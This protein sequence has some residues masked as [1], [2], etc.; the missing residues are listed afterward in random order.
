MNQSILYNLLD[1]QG[2]EIDKDE[3]FGTVAKM[4]RKIEALKSCTGLAGVADAMRSA[5]EAHVG[6]MMFPGSAGA[7]GAARSFQFMP[8]RSAKLPPLERAGAGPSG[9]A[10]ALAR[11]EPGWGAGTIPTPTAAAIGSSQSAT[12]LTPQAA[13][14]LGQGA[15]MDTI[16]SRP[17]TAQF[18]NS[19]LAERESFA[20]GVERAGSAGSTVLSGGLVGVS[21]VSAPSVSALTAVT[22]SAGEGGLSPAPAGA[23]AAAG[24]AGAVTASMSMAS[25]GSVR[26]PG[27]SQSR[28]KTRNTWVPVR[29]LDAL[30]R[31]FHVE[32]APEEESDEG[33]SDV[34]D[35]SL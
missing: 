18:D 11:G 33:L 4:Q 35:D 20:D 29:S 12:S 28:R 14:S 5:A 34:S 3:F 26:K 24:A 27:G 19:S 13:Q 22:E 1:V 15:T 10:R 9:A 2:D 8:R 31:K 21:A 25:R 16:P 17:S 30:M 7:A 23:A 32:R 6:G